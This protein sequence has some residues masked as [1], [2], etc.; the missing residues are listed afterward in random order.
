MMFKQ[1]LLLNFHCRK[2]T[3]SDAKTQTKIKQTKKKQRKQ[4]NQKHLIIIYLL[5]D[6]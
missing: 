1:V 2:L 6:D 3:E 5:Y 4:K